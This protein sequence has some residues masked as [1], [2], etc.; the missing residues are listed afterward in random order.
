MGHV[1]LCCQQKSGFRRCHFV[2]LIL[3]GDKLKS[4]F[5]HLMAIS[6]VKEEV[7]CFR[8]EGLGGRG[9]N[10]SY[11]SSLTFL[12]LATNWSCVAGRILD[13]YVI[14]FKGFV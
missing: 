9:F 13:S 1:R 2:L 8:G 4:Q 3:F 12:E 5:K 14:S 7:L 6:Y 10:V 11:G